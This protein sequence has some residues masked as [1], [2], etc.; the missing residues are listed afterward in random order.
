MQALVHYEVVTECNGKF[1]QNK[2]IF[3]L[4]TL[5]LTRIRCYFRFLKLFY[6]Y[7]L[8]HS[9]SKQMTDQRILVLT[10]KFLALKRM[11]FRC[12]KCFPNFFWLLFT[13][14]Y[15]QKKKYVNFLHTKTLKKGLKSCSES[16][17]TLFFSVQPSPQPRID[18]LCYK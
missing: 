10:L 4:A 18:F 16:A 8:T 1:W 9:R 6:P 15:F 12:K 11:F 5:H 7:S 13:L 3:N 14:K 17:Q 2:F